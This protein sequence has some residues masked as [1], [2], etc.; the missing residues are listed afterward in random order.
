MFFIKLSA[1][2]KVSFLVGSQMI[3]FSG[4][5]SVMPLSGAFGG[6]FGA[7][8]VF[9]IRIMLHFLFFKSLSLS[10]LALCVPGLC[11]SLYWATRS[12]LVHVLLPVACMGLFV[13]HSTGYDAFVYS[14]YWLIPVILFY[15]PY[16]S[17]FLHALGSTFIAHAVGSVIWLYTV[18]MT[19]ATWI[20]LMPL[21]A[22]ERIFFALGMVAVHTV[23]SFMCNYGVELRATFF[24]LAWVL[25]RMRFLVLCA[26]ALSGLCT[27]LNVGAFVVKHL[28]CIMDGNRRW[29][30][31]Q[32]WLSW[33]GHRAGFDAVKRVVQFCVEN[34]ISHLS[35]YTFS[36]ENL[37]RS[38]VER[39]FLFNILAR[40]AATQ[41]EDL[42]KENIRIRF[43]GDH[44]LFPENIRSVCAKIEDETAQCD[45]LQLNFLL[46]YGGQQEIADAAKRI[47]I[48]VA[49]GDL[50]VDDITPEVFK[51]FLWTSS[52]PSPDL[53]IRTGG[54]KR[55]SN[56]LLFQCAYSEL[57]FID[58][59]WPDISAQNLQ[60]AITYYDNC[61][62]NCGK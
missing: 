22:L 34:S 15:V 23:F 9:L 56:F 39:Y 27:H 26:I 10:F 14:L 44:T 30:A 47:A 13:A 8:A 60:A 48:E 5:N 50:Q 55:L 35:L 6:V 49:K 46:C 32:G 2:F 52:S 28:A 24:P 53:I 41:L 20:G 58:V 3:W 11:A 43:I 61:R 25:R 37:H 54:D 40:E 33:Q 38:E 29:A 16:T 1:L 62:K 42:K 57:Y 36:I 17:L 4:I 51:N 12:K 21:V 45:G 19:A 31:N 18:P 7:A 59:L